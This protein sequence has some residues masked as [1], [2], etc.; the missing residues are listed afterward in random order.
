MSPPNYVLV[1]SFLVILAMGCGSDSSGRSIDNSQMILVP[2]GEFRM[3]FN[4]NEFSSDKKYFEHIVYLDNY[5]IDKYEVTVA[6][7]LE[8]IANNKCRPLKSPWPILSDDE[9]IKTLSKS[10]PITL[11]NWNDANKYCSWMEKRLP[12]EAEWEKAARG[13]KFPK[14][15]WGNE[16][17]KQG[18]ASVG[19]GGPKR[20]GNFPNDKSPYGIFDMGGNVSEWVSDWYSKTY[21]QKSPRNNPKGPAHAKL[22]TIR[23]GHWRQAIGSDVQKTNYLSIIRS[24]YSPDWISGTLGF[25][26]AK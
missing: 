9:Y 1:S 8:C 4:Q 15:P 6:N 25:R 22:K 23:G 14:N 11:I 7:Y 18:D 21:Y 17:A 19:L 10:D 12:T 16:P 13:T 5:L 26:C 20:V 3:G 2:V 24:G